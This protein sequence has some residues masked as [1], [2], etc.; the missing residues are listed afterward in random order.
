MTKDEA[1]KLAL[2]ALE[3]FIPYL[4][5]KDEA[6]CNRYDKA[7]TAI[8]E[9]LETKDAPVAWGM[10]TDGLIYDVICPAEHERE[11]GEYTIPLYTHPKE[12]VGLTPQERDE[13]QDQVYG[14]VPH[15]VAFAHAIEAKLK[16]KNT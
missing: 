15:H 7:I 16:E 10:K 4:P 13:I 2:D 12:W 6:Q 3:G 11:E 9:A 14:A 8:K 5:L 1:L